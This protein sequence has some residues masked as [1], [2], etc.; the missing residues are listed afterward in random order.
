MI[1]GNIS[2]VTAQIVYIDAYSLVRLSPFSYSYRY[3]YARKLNEL[4]REYNAVVVS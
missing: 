1:K 2:N 4:M 3:E